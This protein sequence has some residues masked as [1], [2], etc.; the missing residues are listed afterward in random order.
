MQISR[1]GI[2]KNVKRRAFDIFTRKERNSAR[3]MVSEHT[4]D[5]GVVIIPYTN[6]CAYLY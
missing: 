6:Y 5:A 2:S 1:V 3:G 4:L